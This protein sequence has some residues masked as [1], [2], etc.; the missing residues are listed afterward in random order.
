MSKRDK[1]GKIKEWFEAGLCDCISSQTQSLPKPQPKPQ[2]TYHHLRG[3]RPVGV[4]DGVLS[5]V[6]G[7]A[8]LAANHRVKVHGFVSDKAMASESV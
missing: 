3:E 6:L 5:E 1:N 2:L 4:L 7:T 8:P